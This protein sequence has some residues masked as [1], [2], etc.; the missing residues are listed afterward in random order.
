M[1]A[2]RLIPVLLFLICVIGAR[3]YAAPPATSS[4]RTAHSLNNVPLAFEINGG[5]ADQRVQF[6][7]RGTKYTLLINSEEAVLNLR[8]DSASA[9][10]IRM[11]LAGANR[12]TAGEGLEKL[13]GVVSYFIGNDPS[14]W[15]AGVPTYGKVRYTNIY[16]GIDLV[17][18]GNQR[19]LEYDFVVAPGADP[20]RIRWQIEGAK[21]SIDA[22]GNLALNTPNGP[23]RFKK[24]LLYQMNGNKKTVVDGAFKVVR[25][26]VG[27]RIG[28]YDHSQPLIIDPVLVYVSYLGG[29]N[30]GQDNIGFW[31]GPG[32]LGNSPTNALAA[33]SQGAVYVTGYAESID[34]PVSNNAYQG[35]RPNKTGTRTAFVSKFSP[36]G[37]TLE[38]STYLGGHGNDYGYAIAVDAQ[39]NAYVTGT[40]GSGNFPTTSGAYQTVCSPHPGNTP[41]FDS[42]CDGN[43]MTSPFVTKLNP[44]GTGIVYSTFLNGWDDGYALA[45]ALDNN[46][47]AY[48]A[49]YENAICDTRYVYQGCFPTSAGAVISGTVPVGGGAPQ[50]SFAAV[51]DPTGSQ[52]VYSTLMGDMVSNGAGGGN[53]TASGIAVDAN[54]Y[55]YLAGF[56]QAGQ[57]P[58]TPG[59]YQTTS[60]PIQ[61][62]GNTLASARGFV[63]KFNPVTAA[64]GASRAYVTYFGGTTQASVANYISGVTADADGNAYIVGNTNFGDVPVTQG[65]Y[66]TT[67]GYNGTYC[68]AAFVA[69]LTSTGTDLLWSTFVGNGRTDGGDDV[70]STDA[71][72]LDGNGN[73]YIEG[74]SVWSQYPYTTQVETFAQPGILVAELDPTGSHMLFSAGLGSRGQCGGTSAAGMA[75]DAAGKVYLA[76]NTNAPDLVTTTGAFQTTYQKNTC[77][78]GAGFVGVISP[79]TSTSTALSISPG[80]VNYGQNVTFTATVTHALSP[81]QTPTGSVSFTDAG[82]NTL[83]SGVLD[84]SGVATYSSSGLGVANYN[85]TAIYEG[86]DTF[87]GST[88]SPQTLVVNQ[89]AST[90]ISLSLFSPIAYGASETFTAT[91]PIGATGTVNFYNNGVNLLGAGIVSGGVAA[92]STSAL[93]AGSYSITASYSGDSTYSAVTSA[94]QSLIVNQASQTITFTTPAPSSRSY[95]GMFPV[96]ATSSSGLTVTLTVDAS[97]ASV[98]SLAGGI[99]TMNSGTGT[100]VIDANQPGNTNYSG[101]PQAQ[102]SATASKATP[103][104]SWTTAPPASAVYNSQFTVLATGN[105]TGAVTYGVSGGCTNNLG[106]VTITSGTNACLVSASL[107]ADANYIAGSVGPTTVT[108]TKA[109]PT[110][111]WTTPPP[112]SGVYN[113][114]FTVL[115]T[116]NSTGAITYS[117]SGGCTNN[118]GMV[119]MTSGTTACMVSANAAADA[120]YA[121]NLVGPATV[122]AIKAGQTITFNNP[123]AQTVGIP[124]SLV[125][126]ASSALA[127]S[128]AS[129]TTGVC[130]VSGSAATLIVSTAITRVQIPSGTPNKNQ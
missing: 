89:A 6:L 65:A 90:P 84:S 75:V 40:T 19:Q 54:G 21:A 57:L 23:A 129:Q 43:G 11:K 86:D 7:S 22:D 53:T 49:G 112:A 100:C 108:A 109:T 58:T 36:D 39:G 126:S 12:N 71:I 73:V 103:T 30:S 56:T 94:A 25:N 93:S 119:T 81:L 117:V 15:H 55:F 104:F 33:D 50:Y 99:V 66:Q 29:G 116:S 92:Y 118:L 111:A 31:A 42:G 28:G 82:G 8:R 37:S 87:M 10:T 130:T 16:P 14:Q 24:P 79:K 35:T 121:A 101:A 62:G 51:L 106:I 88:S 9:D 48:I 3:V 63:A 114:Q 47:R 2:F 69:K 61:V 80:T 13:R 97:S 26:R 67:C 128:F 45:I 44:T 17:F 124:L 5:Q 127:V 70:Q 64:D 60:G 91:V 34:F 107:A 115:A 77:G 46:G 113:S 38:Y 110:V 76:G 98:C 95:L 52:L 41:P 72:A 68:G 123:G 20:S 32:I 105:S 4:L 125:A 96:A 1:K 27:F 122:T 74:G 102:T 120:N 59:A 85:V 78:Q 18:Y 83:G